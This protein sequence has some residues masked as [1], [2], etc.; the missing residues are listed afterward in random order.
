M[1][2]IRDTF[3]KSNHGGHKAIYTRTLLQQR[4][5][6]RRV[7]CGTVVHV[8]RHVRQ[9]RRSTIQH[10]RRDLRPLGQARATTLRHR[11]IRYM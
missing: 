4:Q 6:S 3:R 9:V 8:E 7:L 10:G 11:E 1:V 5:H 2:G